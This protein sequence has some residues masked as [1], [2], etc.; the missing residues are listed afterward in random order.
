MAQQARSKV[1]VVQG[2]LKKA[3]AGSWRKRWFRLEDARLLSFKGSAAMHPRAVLDLAQGQVH[4]DDSNGDDSDGVQISV[5]AADGASMLLMAGNASDACAWEREFARCIG[6]CTRE[7]GAS[8]G[9]GSSSRERTC[10]NGDDE[11][12]NPRKRK[13]RDNGL[14]NPEGL[15][16]LLVLEVSGG[17][18]AGERFEIGHDGVDIIRKP[19]GIAAAHMKA[20]KQLQLP[21]PDVSRSHAQIRY[22]ARPSTAREGEDDR[23]GSE[24]ASRGGF[25]YSI[26]DLGSLNG[27]IINGKRISAEKKKSEWVELQGGDHILLGKTNLNVYFSVK[28]PDLP[29]DKDEIERK[30]RRAER[31]ARRHERRSMLRARADGA[32]GG[33]G[34][35]SQGG[36]RSREGED[37]AKLQLQAAATGGDGLSSKV[38]NSA[39]VFL[40][41]VLGVSNGERRAAADGGGRGGAQTGSKLAPN[42][43]ALANIVAGVL[44]HNER[45]LEEQGA[46]AEHKR[47][48]HLQHAE[49][50]PATAANTAAYANYAH[51]YNEPY[52]LSNYPE[53]PYSHQP[54]GHHPY[55]QHSY[56]HH[57]PPTYHGFSA[58]NQLV[59]PNRHAPPH[60]PPPPPYSPALPNHPSALPDDQAPPCPR[61]ESSQANTTKKP[62][63][64]VMLAQG[65]PTKF[66]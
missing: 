57:L 36:A 2:Y 3:S 45:V 14:E 33:G 22:C 17:P 27:T 64:S 49:A 24:E 61:A 53:S 37:A 13:D 43:V 21:D 11:D 26:R 50:L 66:K 6:T 35:G 40:S 42:K 16:V 7:P 48:S 18:M 29:P 46:A 60:Q 41:S 9:V 8:T 12:R 23:E 56:S 63:S 5:L 62:A 38:K 25:A 31:K 20:L 58:P 39:Q 10:A 65:L 59:L 47:L 1:P 34:V 52:A 15:P 28:L 54:F 44:D 55:G 19:T 4:V 51:G 32:S 30:R